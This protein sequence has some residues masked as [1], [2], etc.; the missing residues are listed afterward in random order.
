MSR[1]NPLVLAAS[2]ALFI[3]VFGGLAVMK[4]GLYLD[5]HEGDS[6]HLLDILFRIEAGHVPHL[7]FSTPLGVFALLPIT[8]FLEAGFPVGQAIIFSQ[9]AVAA[10]LLPAV[11]YVGW[12]RL[13]APLA[14]A[15]GAVTLGLVLSLSF[16]GT[17]EGTS[18]SMHYN[19]WSW[20]VAFVAVALAVL[21][22]GERGSG[23]ID[24]L[25]IGV[26]GAL[27]ALTKITFFVAL[28]PGVLVAVWMRWRWRGLVFVCAG[29]LAVA[30]AV[31]AFLG[32]GFWSG[33]LA[34][35]ALVSA[36]K[37]RPSVGVPLA[38]VVAGA[39]FLGATLLG[40]VAYVLVRRMGDDLAATALVLLVP[41]FIYV[42][43]QNFGN[44]PL[45]LW[46]LAVLLFA[47]R[48]EAG[49]GALRGHDLR[50][51]MSAAG[52]A[53]LA[54]AFPSLV[55][56]A[57]ST[58][59]HAGYDTAV[60]RPM[61][62]RMAGHQDIFVREGRAFKMTANVHRD[63]ELESWARYSEPAGRGPLPEFQGLTFPYCNWLAGT[64]AALERMAEDLADAGLQP[65]SRLFVTDNLSALWLFGDFA[66]TPGGAPWYY[67]GLSGFE[68]ADYV[69]IPKC[70]LVARVRGIMIDD[71]NASGAGFSLVRDNEILSLFRIEDRG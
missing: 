58:I 2:L 53:A 20:A 57:T 49:A 4:G 29:G 50:G 30:V 37:V 67:G 7:D 26:C 6:Y 48:P 27:L 25:L 15:F 66:P 69:V 22:P 19:R 35:L 1:P 70:A 12:T 68:N 64:L 24:C 62:P 43:Y 23:T 55:S 51:L 42:T 8:G 32:I 28:G 10:L 36:S 31:T 63:R 61:I 52:V 11:V 17:S 46:L 16:G 44:D 56:H 45:W 21:P 3:A 5:A 18:I 54:L 38:K 14:L 13:S 9:L 40:V 33:Y 39:P 59:R 71:L 65:G 41:G 60:Y 34:D 47:L